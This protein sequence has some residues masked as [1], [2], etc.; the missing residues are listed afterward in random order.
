MIT[1][2]PKKECPGPL[3]SLLTTP[4]FDVFSRTSCTAMRQVCREHHPF[5]DLCV[6]GGATD[7]MDCKQHLGVGSYYV[8]VFVFV[9]FVNF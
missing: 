2:L 7:N 5:P 1:S 6:E 4:F 3:S 9:L 8:R